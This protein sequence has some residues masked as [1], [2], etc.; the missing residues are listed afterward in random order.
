MKVT[1]LTVLFL[2]IAQSTSHARDI[3]V[4]NIGG[5][6]RQNG[7]APDARAQGS[8]PCR[9][10]ARALR[11]AKKGD[12][13]I[14]ANTGEPYREAIALA[15]SRH[16]GQEGLPFRLVGNGATLEGA[17][18]VPKDSWEYVKGNVFRFRPQRMSYQ[19]LFLDGVPANQVTVAAGDAVPKLKPLQW[20]YLDR[21]VY[22]CVGKDKVP[23]KY[24]LTHSCLPVGITLYGVQ[25]VEIRDLTI[26]GFQLDGINAND[27]VFGASIL[28]VTAR[29]NAR[30]G[31]SVGGA[32]RV[33]I[34]ASLIGNNGAAQ[35]RTEGFSK[36]EVVNS[37]LLDN[38][39]PK[40]VSDGGKVV[41]VEKEE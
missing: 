29:G 37:D 34:Q 32:S 27:N 17:E 33:T 18:P 40:V 8:G 15:G 10:I 1:L 12:R 4:N 30:S 39:A 25:N 13:I 28:G 2:A 20:C 16:S 6:D 14:I 36:T 22:F 24:N 41:F 35:L 7:A 23:Q 3:F 11:E 9:T 31:V 21:H 38:T 26:Q 5:D 19:L